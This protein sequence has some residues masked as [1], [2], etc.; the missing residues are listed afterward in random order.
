M[1]GVDKVAAYASS[2]MEE[3]QPLVKQPTLSRSSSAK[4][5]STY[6]IELN[7]PY[8]KKQ[9]IQKVYGLLTAQLL[10]TIG[11]ALSIHHLTNPVCNYLSADPCPGGTQDNALVKAAMWLVI[12][13]P[14][15]IVNFVVIIALI[16]FIHF[17][18]DKYPLNLFLLMSFGAWLGLE[19]GAIV[20]LYAQMG[21]IQAVYY[22]LATT[23]AIFCSLSL[24]AAYSK[25]DFSFLWAFLF[26]ALIG[27]IVLG[28]IAMLTGMAALMWLYNVL[29]VLIFSGFILYDTDQIV[30][31][32]SIEACDMGTAILG[33]LE[34][35]L[36]IINLFLHL[37]SLFGN[38]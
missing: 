16:C 27:N 35:Y 36:D 20:V 10:L 13:T 14:G 17:K 18:K 31:R 9:F 2:R 5:S 19:I 25:T 7:E 15:M 4:Y 26:A 34:L 29:G 38:R 28:I 11:V 12:T 1:A 33:A 22:A 23:A 21:K 37:L 32:T 6:D 3:G 24:Y 8:I 30:N